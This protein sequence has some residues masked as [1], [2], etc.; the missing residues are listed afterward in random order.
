[1]NFFGHAAVASWHRCAPEAVFGAMLPDFASI[2]RVRLGAV[3][4]AGIARGVALHHET[5]AVF[6]TSP[7]FVSLC[8]D[9]VAQ[10]EARGLPRGSARAVA[11]VGTEL[12]LDGWIAAHEGAPAEAY[13]AA[14]AV[15]DER[16]MGAVELRRPD[17]T[18]RL[19]WLLDRL[20]QHGVPHRYREPSFVADRLAGALE[21]RP[22][23]RL[24]AAGRASVADWLEGWRARVDL[25]ASGLLAQ[26][27]E[28]LPRRAAG[29]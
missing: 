25:D 18:K 26:V 15:D 7:L 11:H 29:A 3:H 27:R 2:I 5:D 10:L 9:A 23:L 8:N 24:T 22:R 12:L 28:R 4:D 1:M 6:H 19:R 13:L 16:V 17:G 14:I 20:R 21:G